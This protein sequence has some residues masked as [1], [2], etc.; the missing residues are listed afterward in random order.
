MEN[1][2]ILLLVETDNK[3]IKKSTDYQIQGY[4]T[5]LQLL[6]EVN[7]YIDYCHTT[8]HLIEINVTNNR[9]FAFVNLLGKLDY[10]LCGQRNDNRLF[11]SVT[12]I[13]IPQTVRPIVLIDPGILHCSNVQFFRKRN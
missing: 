9:H 1:P 13:Y 7:K 3:T 2:D 5:V 6:D 8:Y 12:V 11:I 10:S 4:E